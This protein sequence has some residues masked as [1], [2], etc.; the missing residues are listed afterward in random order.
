MQELL[1]VNGYPDRFLINNMMEREAK[2]TTPTLE[3]KT[4]FLKVPFQGDAESKPSRCAFFFSNSASNDRH[5]FQ[6]LTPLYISVTT[7]ELQLP[8]GF[9]LTV[10]KSINQVAR[11]LRLIHRPHNFYVINVDKK[12]P[13]D[14][15]VAMQEIAEC[16]GAN[17]AVVPRNESVDVH[18]GDYT[19]LKQELV[20]ARLLLQMGQWRYFINLTGQELALKTNLEL[21]LALRML[22]GSNIVE[23]TYKNRVTW[24]KNCVHV[25]LLREF[26][27]FMLYDL[28]AL[29]VRDILIRY[30]YQ[31]FPDEQ[32]YGT[33]AYNPQLGA[34]GAC[35][36]LY[37]DGKVDTDF[38]QR[39]GIVRFKLW[40]PTPCLKSASS[41]GSDYSTT[42][43]CQQVPRGLI[44]RGLQLSGVRDRQSE[45][46]WSNAQF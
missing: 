10:Y 8:L 42:T 34:P 3:K 19:V 5:E 17:V 1:R 12:S 13:L 35:L 37:K 20:A 25:V 9:I 39:P 29:D 31:N 4:L 41:P 38:E 27:A 44:S 14:F 43:V 23:T 32:F 2:P 7:E 46:P 28:R 21:V 36:G 22:N 40:S 24:L 30:A 11:L 15:Y 45:L 26:V 16:F 33:L 6:R 18:W